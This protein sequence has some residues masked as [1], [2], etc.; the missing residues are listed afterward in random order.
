MEN[1][2]MVMIELSFTNCVCR[3]YANFFL[4]RNTIK[5]FIVL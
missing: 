4:L 1:F 2:A 3:V 5:T